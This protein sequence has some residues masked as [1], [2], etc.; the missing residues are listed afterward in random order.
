MAFWGEPGGNMARQGAGIA[1]NYGSWGFG[2][3]S[4]FISLIAWL[5]LLEIVFLHGLSV[6]MLILA[7]FSS[8]TRYWLILES[9]IRNG[10]RIMHLYSPCIFLIWLLFSVGPSS[11]SC[12]LLPV[13]FVVSFAVNGGQDSRCWMK[14]DHACVNLTFR[15]SIEGFG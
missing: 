8:F 12:F 6:G 7:L 15:G 10:L 11:T 1:E 4:C 9:E 2:N 14:T 5:R 13:P 3:A